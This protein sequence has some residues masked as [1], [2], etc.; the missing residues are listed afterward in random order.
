MSPRSKKKMFRMLSQ[1]S[2][3]ADIKKQ[4]KTKEGHQPFLYEMNESSVVRDTLR[5]AV[6][7]FIL[8][9]ENSMS[10]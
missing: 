6:K 9:D 1:R 10:R 4:L 7:E 8:S 3:F 2:N 5:N